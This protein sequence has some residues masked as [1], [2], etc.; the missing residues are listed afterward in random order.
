MLKTKCDFALLKEVRNRIKSLNVPSSH[1]AQDMKTVLILFF[2]DE[3]ARIAVW[4]H[5]L[6][7]S[8]SKLPD[9][10]PGILNT[11]YSL[12]PMLAINL[13][14]RYKIPDADDI[15]HKLVI[16]NPVPAM[17]Y[18]EAVLY[19]VGSDVRVV[20]T[21]HLLFW[22]PVSPIDSI[23]LFLPPYGSNP[24]VIQYT[25]RSLEH[26]DVNTTFFY[27]PQIVQGLRSDV[28]GYV[29]RFIVETA[30]LSQL[31]AHQIIW[32]MLANS[33]KDEDS[34]DPDAIKPVLDRIQT[35]ITEA[36][37]K[38][39]L[40]FYRDEFGF[41]NEVTSISGKLKPYIKKTKAEKKVKIDEE[42]HK[43]KIKHG[44][45][46]PINPDGIV[47]DINRNS[48]KPL[49]SHAKAPFMATFKIEGTVESVDSEGDIA[50][51]TVERWQSCIFKVG[52]DCR[53]D[54]LALQ[55]ISVFR[56]IWTN[57][58]LD[59]YV[60]PYRVVASAPGCGVIEVLPNSV[61][62][63]MLGREAV[64][65]LYEYFTT[66]FGPESSIEF[67]KARNNLAKSLAAYSIIS[68]LLQF[69]DRHNGNIMY[70]DQGH[71][72]H[73]DFGFCFDIVPGGVRFEAAPFKLTREM[74][75]V[76]GGSSETEAFKWFEELCVKGFLACRPHMD[77][78][79][80]CVTPMLES[81]L[82]CFK[83]G[84]IKNLRQRFVPHKNEGEAASYMRG[85]VR[86]SME[87]LYTKG[88]DEFQRITNGIPY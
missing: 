8:E 78:I 77:T 58:G 10:N 38:D 25:M 41:F 4:L 32:N 16:R 64:N 85:L 19:F 26:H 17:R 88:Y 71:I 30:K 18:P 69:K 67:Q 46:L 73:I 75:T 40:Q 52:D 45:Y 56:S 33:Y 6:T 37:S 29:E 55:L 34:L 57:A 22:E 87:S 82:P 35:K 80:K 74:V 15:L 5:P 50:T 66:K 65:G 28:N 21:Y 20:P 72:L 7:L 31:F 42:M 59:M 12:N 54:V 23:T 9:T 70:D 14:E 49:Q 44:A 53:Q 51:S 11:C 1:R 47:I 76:L 81:G 83:P 39:D 24:N 2:D 68:W 13:A 63:D 61:S 36:F 84:T 3:I 60:Y 86:K 27:V 48:G 62:R 79:I 43:I